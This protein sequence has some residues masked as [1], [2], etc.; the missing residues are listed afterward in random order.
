MPEQDTSD[1]SP[2]SSDQDTTELLP[3]IHDRD[4]N[5][6]SGNN[7]SK[8]MPSVKHINYMLEIENTAQNSSEQITTPDHPTDIK[9]KTVRCSLTNMHSSA[10]ISYK[11]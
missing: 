6:C 3:A 8:K 1:F 2:V 5:S 9:D 10:V 11:A 4:G 7:Q